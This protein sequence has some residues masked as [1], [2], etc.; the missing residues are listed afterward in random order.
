MKSQNRGILIRESIVFTFEILTSSLGAWLLN[1]NKVHAPN[2]TICF[3][4]MNHD[5]ERNKD[6]LG[7]FRKNE[8][9]T[10]K[11]K[12]RQFFHDKKFILK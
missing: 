5:Q 8:T 7:I 1:L 11:F 6:Q 12:L 4:R 3:V 2:K 10:T 9:K